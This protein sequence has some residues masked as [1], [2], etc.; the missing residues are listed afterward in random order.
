MSNLFEML[1]DFTFNCK[2][3]NLAD[4]TIRS[5]EQTLTLF[6]MYLEREKEITKVLQVTQKHIVEYIDYL[7][8]RGKY[9]VVSDNFSTTIN[10]PTARTDYNKKV[11]DITINN[12]IRNIK[13]FFNWAYN[14]K[15]IKKDIVKDIILKKVDRTPKNYIEDIEFK[16][17]LNNLDI[18]KYPEFRDF[19]ITNLLL[20]TGMRIGECLSLLET[21]F[22]FKHNT[23][24]LR[25]EETKGKKHR[26][27]YYSNKMNQILKRW[28]NF[29]DKY[30]NSEY[31]F[32]TLRGT[33]LD[34]S[35]FEKNLTKYGKRIDLEITPH[36]LRNNFAKRFLM[37]GGNIYSLS[38]IL[39]HSSVEVTEQ[40]YLDLTDEDIRKTYLHF[41]PLVN[42]K[43]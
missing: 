27:V 3:R 4:K 21:D 39:G 16:R 31:F 20:D 29:R 9:T 38:K 6:I 26:Q 35:N 24:D 40:A 15:F 28:L 18:S 37:A 10:N 22:D 7:R 1:D 13:V 23:I 42:M 14:E 33:I 30:I 25:A 5:Y 36:Q 17:L 19:C 41:S 8:A 43:R 11:S 12:Y 34:I 32:C 2:V